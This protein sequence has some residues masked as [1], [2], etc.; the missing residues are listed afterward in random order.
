MDRLISDIYLTG[1]GKATRP[2][3]ITTGYEASSV[4]PKVQ[5]KASHLARPSEES[6]IVQVY[7]DR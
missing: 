5:S 6:G 3:V 4:Y 7:Y 2:C 1:T